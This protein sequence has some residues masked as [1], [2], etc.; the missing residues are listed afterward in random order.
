MVRTIAFIGLLA[1]GACG[2]SQSSNKVT[3]AASGLNASLL[4][5]QG[6]ISRACMSAGRAQASRA[7]C[8]CV[9]A[10][11]DQSLSGSDQ[12]RGAKFFDD[13]HRAQETRQSDNPGNEAFWLRWKAFGERAGRLCT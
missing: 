7:R 10:V 9:Q 4:F 13:P 3:S 8:G 11:A 6:P 12:R 5:A 2:A 1:L